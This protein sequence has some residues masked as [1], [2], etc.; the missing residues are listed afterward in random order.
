MDVEQKKKKRNRKCFDFGHC[1]CYMAIFTCFKILLYSGNEVS[2]K[3][4]NVLS[5]ARSKPVRKMN[6]NKQPSIKLQY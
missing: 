3:W 4:A 2:A 5:Y 6:A 1:Q